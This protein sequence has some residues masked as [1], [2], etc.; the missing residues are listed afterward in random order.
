MNSD[1]TIRLGTNYL[2]LGGVST[3]MAMCP[4][5]GSLYIRLWRT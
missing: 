3:R 4:V 5:L 2:G 1:G